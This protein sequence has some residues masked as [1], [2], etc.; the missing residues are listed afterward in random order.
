MK[1]IV[2]PESVTTIKNNAFSGCTKL[3][4]AFIPNS[5]SFLGTFVFEYCESLTDFSLPIN[6]KTIPE[7]MFFCCSKIE[8]ID[9][10]DTIEI[11]DA[12]AFCNCSR[13]HSIN[14]GDNLK[15]IRT[16]AFFHCY[17]LRYFRFGQN[18]ESIAPYAFFGCTNLKMIEWDVENYKDCIYSESP[19]GLNQKDSNKKNYF[20]Y[21]IE[22]VKFGK[23]VKHIPSYLCYNFKCL[24]EIDIPNSVESFGKRVFEGCSPHYVYFNQNITLQQYRLIFGIDSQEELHDWSNDFKEDMFGPLDEVEEYEISPQ[25][26][27]FSTDNG[28]LYNKDG[29]ILYK[30]GR[31]Y[32]GNPF[33]GVKEIAN[34]ACRSSNLTEVTLD[35]ECEKIGDFAFRNCAELQIIEFGEKFKGNG[36][37]SFEGCNKLHKIIWNADDGHLTLSQHKEV[38]GYYGIYNDRCHFGDIE[39]DIRDNI[40]VVILGNGLRI[41]PK[42]LSGLTAIKELNIPDNVKDIC[43]FLPPYL[44]K[45]IIGNEKNDRNFCLENG[46]LYNINKTILLKFLGEEKNIILPEGILELAD[47]A[48]QYSDIETIEFPHSLKVIGEK[49][50]Y[51]SRVISIIMN[52]EL[53]K[54]KSNAF[55]NCTNLKNINIPTNINFVASSII[56]GCSSLVEITLGERHRSISLEG[57]LSLTKIIWSDFSN[58]NY[59]YTFYKLISYEDEVEDEYGRIYFKKKYYY[60]KE[61]SLAH[62]I[63]EIEILSGVQY[64]PRMFAAHTIIEKIHLPSTIKGIGYK[65]FYDCEF[66]KIIEIESMDIEID[67]DFCHFERSHI[68]Y[69]DNRYLTEC[70]PTKIIYNN[71]DVT[72]HFR[73]RN[74]EIIKERIDAENERA[75]FEDMVRSGIETAFEGD[76]EAMGGIW[77]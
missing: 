4:T 48:F 35:K 33:I 53:D 37:F 52:N 17:N 68:R 71:T 59:E 50:F 25:N 44:T 12:D 28:C 56:E 10:P 18:I 69:E 47:Y 62:R 2:I 67:E 74:R 43:G 3:I 5:V 8:N 24:K 11:I 49:C 9:L 6:I 60:D 13:L 70:C 41:L 38:W 39:F 58:N 1:E 51:N 7:G 77:D 20:P 22:N 19:F 14:I 75:V 40:D 16:Q 23:H 42:F 34:F 54:I 73:E 61:K 57:C 26:K 32:F 31:K 76:P 46:F 66:L 27:D 55:K 30:L 64:I 63:K 72:E 29:T 21:R 15:E 36:E 45:L 65:A